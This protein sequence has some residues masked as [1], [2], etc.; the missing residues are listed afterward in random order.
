MRES[1]PG[2]YTCVTDQLTA[3]VLLVVTVPEK[4]DTNPEGLKLNTAED[5]L[6]KPD[7][8]VI[9]LYSGLFFYSNKWNL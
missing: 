3:T 8:G 4:S 9:F 1:C 7:T 2:N 5:R 6:D